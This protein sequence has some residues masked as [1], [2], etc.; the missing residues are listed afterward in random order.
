MRYLV[1]LVLVVLC[2]PAHAEIYKCVIDGKT[3]F[4]QSPCATDA[5]VVNPQYSK[6]PSDAKEQIQARQE[7][8]EK[9]SKQFRLDEIEQ[10][11]AATYQAETDTQAAR[12][13]E[14]NALRVSMAYSNN[15]LAGA[16]RDQGLATQMQAVNGKYDSQLTL[17]ASRRAE[18]ER[19]RDKLKKEKAQ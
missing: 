10:Q 18:L 12:Q 4:S 5:K 15:N 17:I 2:L 14:L 6:P 16:T 1:L 7:A 9:M 13:R 19:E 8:T 11:I 3:T